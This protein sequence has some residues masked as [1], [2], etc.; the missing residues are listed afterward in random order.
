M[1][2]LGELHREKVFPT[3]QHPAMIIVARNR[4]TERGVECTYAT[5]ER[6]RTFETHGV[7]T[8]GP[9][10]IKPLSIRRAAEDE[11]FLKVASWGNA[12]MQPSF[13]I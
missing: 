10:L 11:D 5:V 1:V 9:E 12:P 13:L 6:S 8:I 4:P 2:N 3:A 7:L